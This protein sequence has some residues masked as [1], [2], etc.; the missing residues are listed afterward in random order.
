MPAAIWAGSSNVWLKTGY[1]LATDIE[2]SPITT[3]MKIAVHQ[4]CRE[5]E[6]AISSLGVVLIGVLRPSIRLGRR[7][8]P[9]RV[10]KCFDDAGTRRWSSHSHQTLAGFGTP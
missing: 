4:T 7:T 1:V 8:M 2:P 6:S 3:M 5:L 10:P 9:E